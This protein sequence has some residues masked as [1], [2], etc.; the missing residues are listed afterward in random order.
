M[1]I[2]DSLTQIYNRNFLFEKI[3]EV[4]QSLVSRNIAVSFIMFDIDDFK[5]FNDTYGH[6]VGDDVLRKLSKLVKNNMRSGDIFGRY[7]G[8]EF[9][10]IAPNTNIEEAAKLAENIRSMIEE[11][12]VRNV[13]ASFGVSQIEDSYDLESALK[14]SDDAM[15][16]SKDNGRNKI[17]VG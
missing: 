15:Y 9:L 4:G 2:T 11:N 5:L 13:T 3:K 7:G 17:T 8:E 10:I 12:S 6:L 1:T 16:K 14:R